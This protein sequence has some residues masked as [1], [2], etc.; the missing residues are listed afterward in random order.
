MPDRTMPP[1]IKD[2]VNFDIKLAPCN[3]YTLKNGVPVYY[4]NDGTEEVAVVD[5]VFKAGNNF[6]HKPYVSV[7][8]NALIKNGTS[9]KN[10]FQITK[11]FEYYGAHISCRAHHDTATI[12]VHSLSKYLRIIL[13]LVRELMTDAIFPQNEL[14]IFQQNSIQRLAVSL[15]KCDFVAN[16]LIDEYLYG[17]EHPYGRAYTKEQIADVTRED[18]VNFFK[19]YY[20]NGQC[21]IFSAGKFPADF[22]SMIESNFGDL[23]IGE[24]TLPLSFL[25]ESAGQKKYRVTNDPKGVQGAVR[26]G[27]P[28][29]TRTHPDFKKS[30]VLNVLFGGFFGSRLMSN[31]REEKGYTYGISSYLQSHHDACAWVVSTEAGKDVCEAT[32]TEVYKEMDILRNEAPDEEELLLV[33]NYIMGLNL[34]YIDGP[35]NVIGRWKSLIL[36]GLDEEY[37]DDSIHQIKTVTAKELQELANKYLNP[38]DFFELVVI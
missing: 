20:T 25:V 38:E 36:N 18:M 32:I 6:E 14:D 8:T 3:L 24:K 15:K 33:K 37:F 23:N 13:P 1:L 21:K 26:I 30:V 22:E 29:P 28:F 17:K 9:T 5:F 11:I 2:A 34:G 35:F 4:I 10:A 7:A 31:I 27:R 16:R 19:T 12:T